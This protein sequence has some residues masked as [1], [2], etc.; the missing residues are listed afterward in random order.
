LIRSSAQTITGFFR[1]IENH[2]Q[3]RVSEVQFPDKIRLS[4]TRI[5]NGAEL[6]GLAKVATAYY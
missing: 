6:R 1:E 2:R 3:G 4:L 5:R